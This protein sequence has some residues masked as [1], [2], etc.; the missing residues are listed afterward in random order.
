MFYTNITRIKDF[1]ILGF[2]GL[3]PEYYGPVSALLFMLYLIIAVGNLF[4][5][6]VV[7]CEISLHKPTYLIFCHLALTDLAFGTVTLPKIISKYWFNDSIISFYGCFVQ[8]YFVHSL[9]AIHSFLL[10]VMALDRFI[11]VCAPLRYT[12]L[13]TNTTVSVLCG[14]SW[15]MPMSWMVGIVLDAFTLPFCDSNII[16]QCYC[17]HISLTVLG[18]GNV[19]AVWALA[20]GLAMFSLLLPLGFVIFSYFVIIVVVTRISSSEGRIR[21]MSTCTPQ[22][23]ITF[24]YYMPRCFM[25]MANIVG[26]TFSLPV[27]VVVIMVYSLLPA[28]VNPI[29]YCFKTK[30]IKENLRKKFFIEVN[31]IH[32]AAE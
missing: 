5:L 22:L 20:F 25:Y 28:A 2:P 16:V 6:V 18:C 14:I 30:D 4:I 26:F 9:G 29:I 8:M 31:K 17:D 15:I 7:K 1:F 13:F 21:T 10:M 32:K 24:L 12:V 27:R 11:A 23:L 19:Q 3:S